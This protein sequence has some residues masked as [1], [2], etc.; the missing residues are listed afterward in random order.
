LRGKNFFY[1]MT[2]RKEKD[3]MG[4]VEVPADKYWGAQTQRS[5]EN[6]KIAQDINKMPREIVRAF[7]YLKK[8][9]AL[10]NMD[11]GVLPK[12]KAELISKACDEI[13]QGQLDD[14]FPLVV[15]Q[16]GSGTQS[17]MNVNE[18]IA[19]RAHVLQGGS[20][21]DEKKAIHPND[22]VNKSQSSNDTFPTAM[23]IAAY[24]ILVEVTL[25]GIQK[26]R[27]TLAAKSKAYMHVVKIGRTHLM[28]ATPLTVGQ[29]L[30][31]Y[32]SQLDHGMRAI[33]NTLPHL[34]ELALGGTAVGT[35]LNAP[36]GYDKLVAQKIAELTALPFVT[37]ENKFESLAAH[38][39]I[40]EAHGALKT[41]AC[42]LMKIANDI[43]LL[44]SGPRSGI[45]ELFIPDNEPGSSIMPGKVNP[46]QCEAMTM[47]AAQVLGNDV[48]IN[49]GGANGHFEL[50]VFKPMMIYNFLHSARLIGDVCVS[51]NDKC[52]IGIE[53]L[54]D[55]IKKHVNNSLM[56]V[57]A[58]NTKIGY[59]KAA[60]IAQ[61]AHK[62]GSTLKETAI[63]LGYV[64][65]EQF[66]EW[67]KPEDMCGDIS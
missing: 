54:H 15:W 22:D 50:N 28:D 36:K 3:T 4:V 1:L 7:A 13:L 20:L 16:T 26:L 56:L 57:T 47:V 67:V 48:A 8:A 46:T 35:G 17:N 25:P 63:A 19:Y 39:A 23:H 44:A 32:V 40:V 11:L 45:G 9:A 58:L 61:T 60:E 14:Q 27:D 33:K 42:S 55:N 34:S 29:E 66:D 41:V 10:T 52:A 6:F 64:T 24:K 21:L 30:S 38:D 18:V 5:I 53:P 51:F 59:Y 2:T 12:E 31:G 62:N 43:R 65:A 37:A 49:V